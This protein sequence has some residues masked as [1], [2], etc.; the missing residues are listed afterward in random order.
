[1]IGSSLAPTTTAL[2]RLGIAAELSEFDGEKEFVI[3]EKDLT[4]RSNIRFPK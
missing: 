3:E 4:S 2:P 1:M